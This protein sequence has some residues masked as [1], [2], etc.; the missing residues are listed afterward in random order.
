MYTLTPDVLWIRMSTNFRFMLPSKDVH[1]VH[2][3]VVE[4]CERDEIDQ[5][6]SN[7]INPSSID[8][9]HKFAVKVFLSFISLSACWSYVFRHKMI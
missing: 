2:G 7:H 4:I 6:K 3:C 9:F 1:Q 5:S 8:I